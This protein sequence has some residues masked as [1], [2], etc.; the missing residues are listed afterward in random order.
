MINYIEKDS[1]KLPFVIKEKKIKN[2]YFK[3]NKEFVEVSASKYVS[4]KQ[5]VEL[6]ET[7]FDKYYQ[8][9]IAFQ[10]NTPDENEAILEGN[11]YQIIIIPERKFIYLIDGE[12]VYLFTAT[13]KLEDNKRRL[14][15][16]HLGKMLQRIDNDLKNVLSENGIK[17]RKIILGHYKTKFGSYHR[18]TD[19]IKINIALA[20]YDKNYLYYVLIHEYAHTKVFNHSKDFYN[21]VEKL[22]PN[23]KEYDKN[24]KKMSIWI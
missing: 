7:N 20:K 24:L 5:I 14:Y 22:M 21:L 8:K 15:E 17:E 18:N 19:V 23:Y 13:K 16:K 2:I 3:F 10:S 6:I 4:K 1:R 12:K 9:F 11:K